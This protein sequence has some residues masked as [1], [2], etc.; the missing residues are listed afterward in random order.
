MTCWHAWT[1]AIVVHE[2][3]HSLVARAY[4][5]PVRRI[6]LFAL[7]GVS[8]IEI[9]IDPRF[10]PPAGDGV[11]T[12]IHDFENSGVEG[13]NAGVNAPFTLRF[14][15]K[16]DT[17]PYTLV[18]G[19]EVVRRRLLLTMAEHT[20]M[21]R[22]VETALRKTYGGLVFQTTIPRRTDVAQAEGN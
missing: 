8:Q 19:K 1:V 2:L 12:N 3:A 18:S 15:T 6:T 4:G 20:I 10:G 14:T 11:V 9:D 16:T 7:G 22:D 5:L 17:K 21:A 13:A